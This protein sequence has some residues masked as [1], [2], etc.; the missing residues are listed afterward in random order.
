MAGPSYREIVGAL[1]EILSIERFNV[2]GVLA[3][4]RL[5]VPAF[6]EGGVNLYSYD[7]RGSGGLAK[8]NRGRVNWHVEP[9]YGARRVV[10]VRD[11]A[12]GREQGVLVRVDVD[13]PGEEPLAPGLEPMRII[14]AADGGVTVAFTASTG[15]EAAVYA[16]REGEAWRVASAPGLPIVTGVEGRFAVGVYLAPDKPGVGRLLVADLEEGSLRFK[17]AGGGSVSHAVI[18]GGRVVYAVEA[19][20]GAEL[21]VLDPASTED[22]ELSLPHR[23]LEAFK[24]VAFNYLGFTPEGRLVAVARRRGRS[25][26]FVDGRRIPAPEGVHYSA[27]LVDGRVVFSHSSLKSPPSVYESDPETGEVRVLLSGGKPGWL[28]SRLGESAYVEVESFDGSRVPVFVL[29]SGS[30][31]EPGP[32]VVLVHGGPF[33]EYADEWNVT[34]ASLA[35]AG[36]HVVMPNY[37]GSTG[38]GDEWRLKIIGDPCGGELEDVAAAAR[39]ALESGLASRVY[40]MGYSYG[41]Y[42]A[43]CA[44]TR[45][46][47]LFRAG[48]AGA[49]IVDWGEMY[50]LS[51]AAFKG[52]IDL[53]FA[54]RRDL[55]AER[56]PAS[57]VDNLRDP[58]CIIHPQNDS[59]TPLKPVLRFMEKALEK[60]KS[61][62]AHIA[63]DMGHAITTMEE[64]VK[65]LLP[66]LL[67]LARA[68]ASPGGP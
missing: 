4:G 8:L 34:A 61:F 5:L 17:E 10:F 14:G 22:A 1:E 7:Y 54:G 26:V 60:G 19:G 32:A 3:G 24:P 58:L 33:S 62:E 42:M 59:R 18:H 50:E 9:P 30:A 2:G 66:A 49:G 21:R 13:R 52:F 43:F 16:A 29:R 41:G 55:W 27:Y 15:E 47:G 40:V 11:V 12:R 67:F 23:D 36:F 35:A 6:R 38:Y 56:S 37:R 28:D 31:P 57:Y 44:L 48:V 63:P 25:A 20:E 64:A 51:D 39:W 65:I 53:L 68:E 45:K 46:P